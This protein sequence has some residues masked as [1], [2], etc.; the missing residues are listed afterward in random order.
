MNIPTESEEQIALFEWA[1]FNK[2]K[3]PEL[4]AMYHIPNGGNRNIVTAKRLKAEGVKSGVPD[5]C[6]PVPKSNYHGLYIELKRIKG[7]KVSGNQIE[8]LKMLNANGYYA[9]TCYGWLEAAKIISNYLGRTD[10]E[11]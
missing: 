5:I 6:L 3:Y 2:Y 8:W 9:T 10:N 4:K 1:K 11:F 7:G